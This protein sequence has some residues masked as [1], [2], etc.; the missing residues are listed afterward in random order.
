LRVLAG[1]QLVLGDQLLAQVAACAFGE[2]GVLAVQLHA[3]LEFT[4]GL[5]VLAHAHVAGGHALDGAVFVEQHFGRGK[6][7]ENFHAQGLGLVG[8][9][10]AEEAQAHDVVAFV[11][12]AL[13]QQ[14][15]GRAQRALLAQEHHGVGR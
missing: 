3:Q 12:E 7:R 8:Q 9:P 1:V 5:A 15:V 2:H 4:S 11:V 13:G 10:L 6:A 14:P